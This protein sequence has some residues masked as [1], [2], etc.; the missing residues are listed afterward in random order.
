[1]NTFKK[2]S[3]T[4]ALLS[5]FIACSESPS[6][7][8]AI[9][10]II[11]KVGQQYIPDSRLEVYAIEVYPSH[12]NWVL[13]GTTSNVKAKK[14]LLK[15]VQ[16]VTNKTPIDSITLLP[17][18][19]TL[20]DKIYGVVNLSVCNMREAN[21]FTSSMESQGLLGMPVQVLQKNDW[22]QIQTPDRYIG[23][24]HRTAI[25]PMNAKEILTWKEAPKV[26]VTAHYGFTYE[27]ANTKS[28][29]VSDIVSGDRLV[30]EGTKGKFYAVSYPDGEKAF[31]PLAD[32][33]TEKEWET[34]LKQDSQSIL[35]TAYTLMGI[36]Y[37]WAGASSK[38][39]D[40]SGFVRI[41]TYL[42]G[43]DLPRDASQLAEIGQR[44]NIA[45]D[46]SNLQPADL[47]FFGHKA[48]TDHGPKVVHVAFYIGDKKFIHS[49]GYVH[50]SSFDPND[51]L[52][53]KANLDRLLFAGRVFKDK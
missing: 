24:V 26:I 42:H 14:A 43:I 5:F 41:C 39:V 45:P 47:L 51:P 38:G 50:I 7:E 48:T 20:G 3:L 27:K 25:V 17:D 10:Q 8:T 37:L 30:Y 22:Y 9:K 29:T 33:M 28:Q 4:F 12:H 6:S 18:R 53:D 21:H 13:K 46:F 16:K 44:I 31:L 1:M 35:E 36:P 19:S 49:Q 32:G 52:Y 15:Q 11:K 2:A 34:T 40:C 23:W